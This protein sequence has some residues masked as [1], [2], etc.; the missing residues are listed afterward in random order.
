MPKNT[1]SLDLEFAS[2]YPLK[3]TGMAGH[4]IA[5]VSVKTFTKS[6]DGPPLLTPQCASV[7]EFEH[8]IDRLHKEL[9]VIKKE[10][11]R[12]FARHD[13]LEEQWR[14]QRRGNPIR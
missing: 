14:L 6:G 5:Y 3:G 10:A 8:T 9:E 11:Q 12:K 1:Y 13:E 2:P 4:A 7:Q